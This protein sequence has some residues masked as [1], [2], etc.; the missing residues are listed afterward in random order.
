MKQKDKMDDNILRHIIY[1]SIIFFILFICIIIR[2][3]NY[4]KETCTWIWIINYIGM[5][6]A[7]LNLFIN[8]TISL[9]NNKNEKYKSFLGFTICLIA[10]MCYIGLKIW[11]HQESMFGNVINDVITLLALFFSLSPKIWNGLLNILGMIIE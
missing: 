1:E 10:L 8:K 11:N 9:Y 4:D 5:A 3:S 6:T 2:I 7:L